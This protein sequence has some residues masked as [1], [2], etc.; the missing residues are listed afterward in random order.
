MEILVADV[1][2]FSGGERPVRIRTFQSFPLFW[3]IELC[4]KPVA[5]R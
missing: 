5:S 4:F 3:V 1:D 2:H